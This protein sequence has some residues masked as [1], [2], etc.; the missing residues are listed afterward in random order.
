MTI[1]KNYIAIRGTDRP[2]YQN[3]MRHT[4]DCAAMRHLRR[5]D[6]QGS[7]LAV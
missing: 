4:A 7:I 3:F 1:P 5:T 2:K 6:S